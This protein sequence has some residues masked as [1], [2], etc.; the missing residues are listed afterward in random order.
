VPAGGYVWWYLDAL[1]DDGRHGLTLIG[2]IGSVFS[3]YYARAQRLAGP[4]RA[5]PLN[6]CALNVVLYGDR[7]AR[8][9]MTERGRDELDRGP[10]H[11]RIG[12]SALHWAG[13]MLTVSLDEVT[14]PWPTRLRGAV[15]VHAPRRFDHPVALAP[16][17][18]WCPIAPRARVEVALTSPAVRWQGD[19]YLDANEGD[20]PLAEAFRRWDW[21]RAHLDDR[22]SLVVY[23][24][25]RADASRL[26]I[27]LRFGADGQVSTL[28]PPP[29]VAL[30]R[31]RWGVARGACGDAG[32][33]VRVRRTLTDAPFYAR[34]LIDAHWF[35]VPV[36]AMH[37]SLSLTRFDTPWV[38]AM[39]PFRMP[40]RAA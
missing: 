25:Q 10:D 40:R 2:F 17:H 31:T 5:D 4:G 13:D 27:G 9:A 20:A 6:H 1:S 12:P 38:Q 35:G 32:C 15:R 21:S 36:T 11:L 39:L 37:E 8:W 23:D 3:P 22:R 30:P 24:V 18:R 7:G 16:G 29:D 26:Q 34:S 33:P 28:V 14:V 19:G